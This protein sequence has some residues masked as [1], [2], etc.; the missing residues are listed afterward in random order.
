ML[1]ALTRDVKLYNVVVHGLAFM[2]IFMAF[3][4]ASSFNSTLLTNMGFGDL[5]YNS[6]AVIYAVFSVANFISPFIVDLTGPRIGMALGGSLYCLFIAAFLKPMAWSIMVS[7]ALLGLGAAVLW[8]AQGSFVTLNSD[9]NTRG[10]NSGIFWA[11]LQSSILIG[12]LMAYFVLPDS[13]KVSDDEAHQFYMILF[14]VGC[15][16]IFIL[17]LTRATPRPAIEDLDGKPKSEPR[18][19]LWES[20]RS[21]FMLLITPEMLQL[22]FLIMYSGL[23]NSFWAGKYP[24]TLGNSDN[25]LPSDFKPRVIALSGIVLGCSQIIGGTL[26]GRVADRFGKSWVVMI[27][28][29]CHMIS[30]YA[31][32]IN[33]KSGYMEPSLGLAL[34]CSFGLGLGDSCVN[35]AL[36]AILSKKYVNQSLQAFAIFK[37]F[38]SALAGA[39]FGYSD[40]LALE[41]QL[42]LLA[43]SA[44][45]GALFFA[46]VDAP[47]SAGYAP[48]NS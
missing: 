3:Q 6:L 8:T 2:C 35:T 45:V 21:T 15:G 22:S 11:L 37:C 24:T 4:T 13:G 12:N 7:S 38:Q 26:M 41:Y 5:G 32:F 20:I 46:R 19:T 44:I 34:V 18:L 10:R 36:Y 31:I 39:A 33:L 47:S 14:F 17:L 42:L 1:R 30:F 25:S 29:A 48:L 27:G 23:E 16:G 40:P 28:L 43:I 9:E